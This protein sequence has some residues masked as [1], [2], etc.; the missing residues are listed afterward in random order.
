MLLDCSAN[1]PLLEELFVALHGDPVGEVKLELSSLQVQIE[2]SYSS[3][4][5]SASHDRK[6][7]ACAKFGTFSIT[8]LTHEQT[9]QATHPDLIIQASMSMPSLRKVRMQVL[10]PVHSCVLGSTYK[11]TMYALAV[12]SCPPRL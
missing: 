6:P 5:A 1:W 12:N 9:Q 10:L 2:S 11:C 8:E 4:D 3:Q 7:W